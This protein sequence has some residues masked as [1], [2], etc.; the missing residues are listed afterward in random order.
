MQLMAS[1]SP[2]QAMRPMKPLPTVRAGW[3]P[4]ALGVATSLGSQNQL[5]YAYFEQAERLAVMD[6]SMVKIYNTGG[7]HINGVS[8]HGSG[9]GVRFSTSTGAVELGELRL[10]SPA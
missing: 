9:R 1:I 3:W 4:R 7:R 10:V 8:Q 5:H 6:G 2:M